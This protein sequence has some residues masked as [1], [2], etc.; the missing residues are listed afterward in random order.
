MTGV[1]LAE[2]GQAVLWVQVSSTGLVVFL[3]TSSAAGHVVFMAD[4]RSA[5]RASGKRLSLV[6]AAIT[7]NL[8]LMAEACYTAEAK[9]SGAKHTWLY[10]SHMTEETKN[11]DKYS[12]QPQP[13]PPDNSYSPPHIKYI[14]LH[15]E[16]PRSFIESPHQA[17]S[18]ESHDWHQLQIQLLLLWRLMNSKRQAICPLLM[19][20]HTPLPT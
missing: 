19:L 10:C 20:M 13:S 12:S 2:I 14:H 16:T 9:V 7:S 4:P 3:W 1:D 8:S 5:W 6:K 15:T 18:P 11:W 17:Q